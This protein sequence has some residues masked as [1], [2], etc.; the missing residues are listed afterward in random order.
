[1]AKFDWSSVTKEDVIEAIN[2]F[3]LENPE[4][5][6]PRSTFLLYDGEKLPAKHIRGMA[7]KVHHNLEISKEDYAGG[8]ETVRFFQKLGFETF[9][10]GSSEK[11]KMVKKEKVVNKAAVT[12]QK[13]NSS[14]VEEIPCEEKKTFSENTVEIMKAVKT[15]IKI[16][17]KGV[18]EQKNALQLILNKMF[19]GDIVCEKTFSWMRTPDKIEDEYE[20]LYKRLTE[21]RGDTAFAKKNVTLRCDFVI[22]S[23]KLIIEY[24]ERQHF[25]EARR[26]SLEAYPDVSLCFDRNLWIKA[27]SDIQAKDGQPSNRDE[28]R[29]Y[30]DSTRDIEASKHGYTLVRIMHGQVDFQKENGREELQKLL[31]SSHPL[32]AFD[33]RKLSKIQ[34]GMYLQTDDKKNKESFDKAMKQVKS[35]N[36]EILVFPEFC[37]VPF[38]S[39]MRNS[40]ICLDQDI[41][42]IS[43]KCLELSKDLNRAVIVSSEDKYGTIFSMYANAFASDEETDIS[44]YL[45]H[46]M[47]GCSAFEL[48]DYPSIAKVLFSPIVYKDHWI[49]MTICYDCNH[50]LF[51]RMYGVQGFDII[52]NSTGGNV[53]YDK[54]YKYNQVRAIENR[55]FTFVTMGGDVGTNKVN[56]Y[57]YGFSPDG[58][59]LH[60]HL[61][62]GKSEATNVPG[63]I[64]VYDLADDNASEKPEHS[65]FQLQTENKYQDYFLPVGNIESELQKATEIEPGLFILKEKDK[66][67]VF[68]VTND[69]EIFSAEEFLPRMYSDRLKKYENKRYILVNKYEK[70]EKRLYENQLSV[71]LKVR[72]ME[73]FCAVVLE[74]D[75]VCNCYQTGKSKT[76]QV[77]KP[78]NGMYGLDL[79]RMTGPEAIWKNKGN[80]FKASWRKNFTWLANECKHIADHQE[81]ES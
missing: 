55:C 58:L 79:S 20:T 67:I 47:T 48:E 52:I 61:L 73:N 78:E 68:I 35:S 6:A 21:Y 77:I 8:I 65:L 75:M 5:P 59:E 9:H 62:N 10:V 45:K 43:G 32:D 15:R 44:I 7:Y 37:Y 4:Y 53:V 64:Y 42:V 18:I 33:I 50:V 38:Y 72:A 2:I 23:K 25:S 34:I 28:I 41:D 12:T 51:S 49:G 39:V 30:Y 56:S 1:M 46:T 54:W 63:G 57:V 13:W 17:S 31:Q 81:W 11:E 3:L 70:L 66:Y 74:S 19:D 22:E 60:P 80:D 29:A 71:V 40:D 26:I 27:C 14:R 36:I 76:A 69:N 16:P 24:D